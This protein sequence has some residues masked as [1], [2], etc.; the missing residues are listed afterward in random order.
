MTATRAKKILLYFAVFA[1]VVLPAFVFTDLNGGFFIINH[2][3]IGLKLAL[4]LLL[5]FFTALLCIIKTKN[6]RPLSVIMLLL[7]PAFVIFTI[8]FN[9][10][11]VHFSKYYMDNHYAY[12]EIAFFAVPL[13]AVTA[14][15]RKKIMPADFDYFIKSFFTG[16]FFVFVFLFVR[17][18]YLTRVDVS[19]CTVNLIPF[20][21]EISYALQHLKYPTVVVH[22]VGNLLFFSSLS[23]MLF[24]FF[25]GKIRGRAAEL[26]LYIGAPFAVS[27]LCEASQYLAARGDAD[28]DDLLLN[29]LGAAIGYFAAKEIQRLVSEG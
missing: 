17:I 27:L 28:I 13:A 5:P 2:R 11:Y 19:L 21:G 12:A 15:A 8:V 25:K 23:L 9:N 6:L 14:V 20:Q 29:T 10:Y 3:F 16:Y 24:S 4:S 7:Q 18:F 22:M 26:L 1:A